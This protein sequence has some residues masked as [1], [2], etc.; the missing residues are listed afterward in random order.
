MGRRPL[1]LGFLVRFSES[2]T[3]Y[4][5]EYT[6]TYR[7]GNNRLPY[8]F[9]GEPAP[10]LPLPTCEPVAPMPLPNGYL[11]P[12]PAGGSIGELAAEP[13]ADLVP[14]AFI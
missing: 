1:E 12:E 4:E 3:V 11:K 13:L 10:V 14:T 9:E 6:P 5:Y 8:S 2:V 7:F